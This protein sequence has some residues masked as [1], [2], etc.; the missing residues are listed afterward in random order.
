L[1]SLTGRHEKQD[2]DFP[3]PFGYGGGAGGDSDFPTE[4]EMTY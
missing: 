3:R 1:N 4:G 2:D